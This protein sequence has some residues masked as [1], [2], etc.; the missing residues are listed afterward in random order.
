MMKLNWIYQY[1]SLNQEVPK[2]LQTL[3]K[4][5]KACIIPVLDVEDSLQIPLDPDK[6]RLLKSRAREILYQVL[7]L[8]GEQKIPLVTCLRINSI[9]TVEFEYDLEM[10]HKIRSMVRW[11]GIFLPK[12][13][14]AEVLESYVRALDGIPYDELVV[15]AESRSFFDHAAEI[16]G[17]CKAR[18]IKKIHFGHWDYFYD[19][20]EFPV[21]LPDDRRLWDRVE[22]LIRM[23][24]KEDLYYIHTPFCFLMKHDEFQS[25][26]TY[27]NSLTNLPFGMTTL[28]FSQ[29]QAVCRMEAETTPIAPVRYFFDELQKKEIARGLANFFERPVSPEYSFNIDT[30][31]YRFYAPHEYLNALDFLEKHNDGKH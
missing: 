3:K 18:R 25:V 16:T 2:I 1:I 21:P 28:S 6:T 29:A 26:A 5:P 9:D 17:L 23:I 11:G 24:E 14:S 12:V 15:M 30:R 31:T 22:G 10:L 8:A 19:L 27:L 7:K 20:R 13:H 4:C